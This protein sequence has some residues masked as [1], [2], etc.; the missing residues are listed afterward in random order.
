LERLGQGRSPKDPAVRRHLYPEPRLDVRLAAATAAMDISDGLSLDLYRLT[1][2]SRVGADVRSAG[3]PLWSGA[4]L[5]QALH[6]GEDYE[7]L[8]TIPPD[9]RPPRGSTAIGAI[10]AR[11]RLTL[12]TKPLP[13][14]GFQHDL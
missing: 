12:D 2:A 10:T 11:R 1:K 9:R 14:Q 6:G 3:I 7:L 8:F 5:D 13:I 4:S